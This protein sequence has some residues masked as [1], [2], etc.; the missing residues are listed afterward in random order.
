MDSDDETTHIYLSRKID[1]TGL[2]AEWPDHCRREPPLK[3][4]AEEIDDIL[5]HHYT[6]CFDARDAARKARSAPNNDAEVI[7]KEEAEALRY[8]DETCVSLVGIWQT[9]CFFDTLAGFHKGDL[10]LSGRHLSR[11]KILQERLIA[12]MFDLSSLSGKYKIST[13]M[14]TEWDIMQ[15]KE[16][17]CEVPA[18]EFDPPGLWDDFEAKW[19][20]GPSINFGVLTSYI[21]DFFGL[22]QRQ[23][24]RLQY[25]C[26]VDL[27]PEILDHIMSLSPV[28]DRRRWSMTCKLL[29]EHALAKSYEIFDYR[30]SLYETDFDIEAH[31]DD[32][33]YDD[34]VA[35]FVQKVALSQRDALRKRMRRVAKRQDVL[36]KIR[37]LRFS[38][39]WTSDAWRWSG[40]SYTDFISP[41]IHALNTHIRI[42][43]LAEL[44]YRTRYL[45]AP[46]WQAIV[47]SSSLRTL[48]LCTTLPVHP[49]WTHARNV[50]N[51][52]LM[53]SQAT[54]PNFLWDII[55]ACPSALSVRVQG[56]S[57]HGI[58]IPIT[59]FSPRAHNPLKHI[60]RLDL[61]DLI[62]ESL[63][64]L[65]TA[66]EAVGCIPL[67]HLAV[68]TAK[69]HI[70][71]DIAV[72]LVRSLR[73]AEHLL[74]LRIDGL[75]Y[76]KPDILALIGECVPHI[77]A[78]VLQHQASKYFKNRAAYWPCP[79]HEYAPCLS[80][81]PHLRHLGLN[82][83]I[84]DA[85]YTPHAVTYLESDYVGAE[86][87]Y[88]KAIAEWRR[89]DPS[90]HDMDEHPRSI[91]HISTNAARATVRLFAIHGVALRTVSLHN[92]DLSLP[93]F[94]M[95]IDRDGE[96]RPILRDKFE[97]DEREEAGY[98]VGSLIHSKWMFDECQ[99][100]DVLDL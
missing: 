49:N 79:A 91:D 64:V 23:Q 92:A 72:V 71:K 51:L 35:A 34:E 22:T 48:V 87:W 43:P 14:T 8:A 85:L 68:S 61:Q 82:M 25:L 3:L 75:Q 16:V 39:D 90:K 2:V 81:F 89:E 5:Q 59:V 53:L 40:R 83:R 20:I 95:G 74:V 50:V 66:I 62:A 73:R 11:Y 38:E 32:E 76:A 84:F 13:R 27:P 67:T 37:V 18:Y 7:A 97:D 60:R 98:A 41:L 45:Y 70:K 99:T 1:N 10:D 42:S 63:L 28:H 26:L 31:P 12:M 24:L 29:R 55:T 19:H 77:E 44:T 100:R 54:R 57:E 33:G 86:D 69:S 21:K 93:F 4:H 52:D 17:P 30:L 47:Q 46:T 36:S 9:R 94:A 96:G 6:S 78:L 58:Y 56:S 80:A 15:M 65:A 88:E